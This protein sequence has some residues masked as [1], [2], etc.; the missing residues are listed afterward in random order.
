MR[1]I[2][3]IF[4]RPKIVQIRD[5][6]GNVSLIQEIDRE[7]MMFPEEK[8]KEF[9][10]TKEDKLDRP[11]SP[12]SR[13]WSLERTERGDFYIHRV[14][15]NPIVRIRKVDTFATTYRVL[16]YHEQNKYTLVRRDRNE[17]V[18]IDGD[19]ANKLHPIDITIMKKTFNKEKG[20]TKFIRR[21]LHNLSQAGVKLFTR[22]TLTDFDLC[23]NYELINN[24]KVHMSS[25]DTS[26]PSELEREARTRVIFKDPE[27]ESSLKIQNFQLSSEIMTTRRLSSE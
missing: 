25:L 6:T 20:N 1:I 15:P 27:L 26:I 19:L 4:Q 8:L 10:W 16:G 13:D 23:I 14:H 5:S 11:Q 17:E 22:V 9:Y 3:Y 2:C 21:A 24:R 12:M 7:D 18:I